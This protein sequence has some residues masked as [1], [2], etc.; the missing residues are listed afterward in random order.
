MRRP[1]LDV[2]SAPGVDIRGKDVRTAIN[3]SNADGDVLGIFDKEP[4]CQLPQSRLELLHVP[5]CGVMRACSSEIV[6]YRGYHREGSGLR[7]GSG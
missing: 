4:G 5:F 1:Q 7:G 2:V 6:F 3:I